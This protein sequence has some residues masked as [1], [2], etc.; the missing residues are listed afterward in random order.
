MAAADDFCVLADLKAWLPNIGNNDDANLQSLI[1]NGSL[2]ILQYINRPHILAS[3]IGNLVETYDG[4]GSDKLL[5]HYYPIIAVSDVNIDAVDIQLST[6]PTVPGFF[7]DARRIML[8]GFS[9][10]CRG[11]H[12]LQNTVISYTAGFSS[13]P[14]DL[15]QAAIEAFALTYRGRPHIGEK[16]NSMGGQVTTSFDMTAIPARSLMVFNQYRRLAL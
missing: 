10:G 12:N 11:F 7:W 16:S 15:K 13:M 8:R 9:F 2:Q 6:G 14:L 5:P 1:T 4:N 3:V